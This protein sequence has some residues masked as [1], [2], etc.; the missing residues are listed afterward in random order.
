MRMNG[1]Q[2]EYSIDQTQD[3]HYLKQE[4][5]LAKQIYDVLTLTFG[6]VAEW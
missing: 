4:M 3:N 6:P 1:T 5:N 2:S